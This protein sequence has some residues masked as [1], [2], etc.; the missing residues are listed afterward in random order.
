LAGAI[1]EYADAVRADDR[2]RIIAAQGVL[3]THGM[4]VTAGRSK[5]PLTNRE[6]EVAKLAADGL[7]NRRIAESLGLSVRTI[8][9]HLSRV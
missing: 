8:D 2:T 4:A 7:S 1:V 9:A 6:Y 5:T 3:A